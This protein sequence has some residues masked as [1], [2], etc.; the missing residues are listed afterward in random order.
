MK[1]HIEFWISASKYLAMVNGNGLNK[2]LPQT[3]KVETNTERERERG[4]K[5]L[6]GFVIRERSQNH[7][8]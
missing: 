4:K 1:M 2:M 8:S 3:F 7:T 6:E 5:L